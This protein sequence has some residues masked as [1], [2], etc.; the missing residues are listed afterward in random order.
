MDIALRAAGIYRRMGAESG[1]ELGYYR[2]LC[3]TAD[4][5][6][7]LLGFISG[8]TSITGTKKGK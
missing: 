4:A 8:K 7:L 1:E 3:V 2:A 5:S 6:A